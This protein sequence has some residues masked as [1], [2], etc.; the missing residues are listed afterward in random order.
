MQYKCLYKSIFP[1]IFQHARDYLHTYG[2]A[3]FV[4]AF[5]RS[6]EFGQQSTQMSSIAQESRL[7][8]DNLEKEAKNI[9]DIAEKANATSYEAYELTKKGSAQQADITYV[10]KFLLCC[11]LFFV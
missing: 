7:L 11:I 8:A 1:I 6:K 9:R 3:A 4:K 10:Y 2:T 5:N